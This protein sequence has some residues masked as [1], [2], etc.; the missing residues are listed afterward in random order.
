MN[1]DIDQ[2]FGVFIAGNFLNAE[3][4]T[5]VVGCAIAANCIGKDVKELR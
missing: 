2:L 4:L 5:D 3:I 1:E